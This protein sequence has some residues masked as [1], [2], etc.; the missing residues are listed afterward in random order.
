M[1]VHIYQ[2]FIELFSQGIFKEEHKKNIETANE[3]S[4]AVD[5][6]KER[7]MKIYMQLPST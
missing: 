5:L 6:L 2:I 3:L 1:D 7:L 4:E